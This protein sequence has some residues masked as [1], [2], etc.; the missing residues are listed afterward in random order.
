MGPPETRTRHCA[1]DVRAFLPKHSR[2]TTNMKQGNKPMKQVSNK[3]AHKK[4]NSNRKDT[5][6]GINLPNDFNEFEVQYFQNLSDDHLRDTDEAFDEDQ[7]RAT[8]VGKSEPDLRD[9]LEGD[10]LPQTSASYRHWQAKKKNI[11]PFVASKLSRYDDLLLVTVTPEDGG[12]PWAE[13]DADELADELETLCAEVRDA[14]SELDGV[15]GVIF[16]VGEFSSTEDGRIQAHVHL[17]IRE[18]NYE[19][20]A[21][22]IKTLELGVKLHN[23]H[24]DD[25][26]SIPE[27]CVQLVHYILKNNTSRKPDGSL[28][29]KRPPKKV[30]KLML[31]ALDRID[32][33]EL[34]IAHNIDLKKCD[35]AGQNTS[36][37][38]SRKTQ[39]QRERQVAD[40]KNDKNKDIS[41][42]SVR[43]RSFQ[44]HNLND[45]TCHMMSQHVT[46]DN[47]WTPLGGT[48]YHVAAINS[49]AAGI[50]FLLK[51]QDDTTTFIHAANTTDNAA[52]ID[53]LGDE[54]VL[55]LTPKAKT[56]ALETIQNL[57]QFRTVTHFEKAGL[58]AVETSN[59]VQEFIY[60]MPDGHAVG[61]NGSI[62]SANALYLAEKNDKFQWSMSGSH[63]VWH[64]QIAPIVRGLP[65]PITV[66]GTSLSSIICQVLDSKAARIGTS[67]LLLFG[68]TTVGKTVI[69]KAL[70]MGLYGNPTLV[71]TAR[72]TIANLTSNFPKYDSVFFALDEFTN[73]AADSKKREQELGDFCHALE[74]GM[75]RQRFNDPHN[76]RFPA[77][78]ATIITS[79]AMGREHGVHSKEVEG[80]HSVRMNRI[81][82][83]S[84]TDAIRPYPTKKKALE[85]LEVLTAENHGWIATQVMA[86]VCKALTADRDGLIK[87][88][89]QYI[90]QFEKAAKRKFPDMSDPESR[91]TGRFAVQY[92][93]LK[94]AQ[95]HNILPA[96]AWGSFGSPLLE[97]LKMAFET[98]GLSKNE[99]QASKEKSHAM[100]E[101]Y[102]LEALKSEFRVQPKRFINL[103]KGYPEMSDAEANETIFVK[104]HR[105][106]GKYRVYIKKQ[107]GLVALLGR[108]DKA[109][110]DSLKKIG[111]LIPGS[112]GI[113]GRAR[114][115]SNP[116]A[117]RV[118]TERTYVLEL[119]SNPTT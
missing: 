22:A 116:G 81:D 109:T 45:V 5:P 30:E 26:K 73:L 34:I 64:S 59:G 67:K 42:K 52:V 27:N 95:K 102:V 43:I 11:V 96:W 86:A 100:D 28:L 90:E 10:E 117:E 68:E 69:A 1:D 25:E 9:E 18:I 94:F 4:G 74:A 84:L 56:S 65:I 114:L 16:A 24:I 92:A 41:E 113:Q 37:A 46:R 110:M 40:A 38:K 61:T 55:L 115:R 82:C 23:T 14:L 12:I 58:H 79:N 29:A 80:G 91:I 15:K 7:V 2:Q 62:R 108:A 85:Q 75:D 54:K 76:Q 107:A 39:K 101:A 47:R 97:A 36:H 17:I 49:G 78:F 106:T 83:S 87:E 31:S 71:N 119:S 104:W 20:F 89:D 3:H 53:Q 21:A 35:K 33:D 98:A 66:M 48:K 118:E 88:I 51:K 105:S 44:I 32:I 8:V 50:T 19:Q 63:E 72:D 111:V 57:Q 70:G 103:E 13:T 60:L 77:L 93:A 112:K 99:L 6:Y